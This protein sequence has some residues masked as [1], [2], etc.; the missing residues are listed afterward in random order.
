MKNKMKENSHNFF[1]F[2]LHFNEIPIKDIIIG[3]PLS[4]E[5]VPLLIRKDYIT[6][7]IR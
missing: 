7:Y 2:H 6:I 5:Q 3:E 4:L 1:F